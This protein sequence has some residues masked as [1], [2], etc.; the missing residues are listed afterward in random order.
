MLE[1][2]RFARDCAPLL[3]NVYKRL[4]GTTHKVWAV[5]Y[6]WKDRYVLFGAIECNIY[7]LFGHVNTLTIDASAVSTPDGQSLIVNPETP[8]RIAQDT[9][10]RIWVPRCW[11]GTG[12]PSVYRDVNYF[13]VVGDVDSETAGWFAYVL[14]PEHFEQCPPEE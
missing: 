14:T 4:D 6:T 11:I 7:L 3:C 8:D 5:P 9:V 2:E 10:A 1:T 12:V 13:A